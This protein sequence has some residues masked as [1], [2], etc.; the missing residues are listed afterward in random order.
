MEP[1]QA[2]GLNQPTTDGD[3]EMH[4]IVILGWPEMGS[5]DTPNPEDVAL[6]ESREVTPILPTL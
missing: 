3:S 1:D 5:S 4:A 6:R 2:K